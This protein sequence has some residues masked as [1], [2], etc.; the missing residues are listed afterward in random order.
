MPV[1]GFLCWEPAAQ[2]W[3]AVRGWPLATPDVASPSASLFSFSAALA[4]SSCSSACCSPS[5][6]SSQASCSSS[7]SKSSGTTGARRAGYRGLRAGRGRRASGGGV[8][9]RCAAG[10]PRRSGGRR[11]GGR[12][13]IPQTSQNNSA[14]KSCRRTW[15]SRVAT[16]FL[17]AGWFLFQRV[18]LVSQVSA[19]R[20]GANLGHP[21]PR[22]LSV[23]VVKDWISL[24]AARGQESPLLARIARNR[25]VG[26]I[27]LC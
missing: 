25:S 6:F 5:P 4:S 11:E 15:V 17:A 14:D 16:F 13:T 1:G 12:R 3:L 7:S 8:Q 27:Q 22:C 23:S 21:T 10:S 18:G 20:A 24:R 19:D 9:T 26:G 2:S